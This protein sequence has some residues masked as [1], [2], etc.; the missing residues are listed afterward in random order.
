MEF[1]IEP[2]A[3]QK[4][5]LERSQ[6]TKDMGLLWEMGTGK[7]GGA[8]LILRDKFERYGEIQKTV[9][10]SPIVTLENWRQ[11]IKMHSYINDCNIYVCN[12]AGKKRVDTI[13]E[14]TKKKS[15]IILNYEAM[16]NKNVRELLIKWGPE[17]MI[18]DES[19]LVKN[20]TSK[21]SKYVWELSRG[22]S[23]K[24]RY[25][26]TGTPILNS[27]IDLYQQ[28]KILDGGETFGKNFWAFRAEYFFDENAK[29]VGKHNYFPK[30][31]PIKAKFHELTSKVYAK[32]TRILKKNCLDLPP[33]V[34]KTIRLPMAP[35]Q[36]RAYRD[37]KKEFI[38]FV[39]DA[40]KD[41]T[42]AAVALQATTKAIRLQQICCGFI[43][44]EDGE[45]IPF[46]Y[47]PKLD[48]TRD[49]LEQIT[50]DH[51]VIVWT[52]FIANYKMLSDM[53]ESAG[54]NYVL[55]TGQQSNSQKEKSIERFRKEKDCRVIVANRKTGGT[56]VNL[57]EASYSIVFGR[58]FNLANELQSEAR[59]YR[60]GSEAHR[61][62]TKINLVM[63]DSIDELIMTALDN[64][65]EIS[66]VILDLK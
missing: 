33:Y 27:P 22:E 20:H 66:E 58:D 3:H 40:K 42:H 55:L 65:Q 6:K 17:I 13:A 35:D 43:K 12:R 60:A 31:V 4:A 45:N 24:H 5:A 46:K 21:R 47:N 63:E 16:L 48:V 36:Y 25:I 61:S 29:W 52:S 57:T 32:S 44:T 28:Y 7:T 18:C 10:F 11:E 30:F 54:I 9:I 38:T 59:N 37:M 19:H 26:L 41:K 15:I 1:K 14:A 34:V 49:I 62:I 2:F 56:G 8:V 51:K 64:T 39:E 50:P 23:I 53:L